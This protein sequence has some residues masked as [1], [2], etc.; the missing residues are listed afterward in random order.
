MQML[1]PNNDPKH[2]KH[3]TKSKDIGGRDQ[4]PLPEVLLINSTS[5]LN[6]DSASPGNSLILDVIVISPTNT[7][8]HQAVNS[9]IILGLAGTNS[10]VSI[11]CVWWCWYL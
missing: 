10:N 9:G 7:P 6:L 1:G 11:S 4:V 8:P 2:P 5:A 3:T